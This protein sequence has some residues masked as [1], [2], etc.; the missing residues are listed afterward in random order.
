MRI[1]ERSNENTKNGL[2]EIDFGPFLHFLLVLQ[3]VHTKLEWQP[4]KIIL[5]P[6]TKEP[7]INH[8]LDVSSVFNLK[9]CHFVFAKR[10]WLVVCVNETGQTNIL[11]IAFKILVNMCH[12]YSTQYMTA[13]Y[14]LPYIVPNC[15]Q[16]T[17]LYCTLKCRSR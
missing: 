15:K 1:W 16:Y 8:A 17:L 3:Q 7:K 5:T 9:L 14:I 13:F 4:K 2:I 12:K 11:F 10:W 6:T